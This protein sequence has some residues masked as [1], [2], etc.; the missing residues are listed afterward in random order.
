M[1]TGERRRVRRGPRD[2]PA[3]LRRGP[4]AHGPRPTRARTSTVLGSDLARKYDKH[5]GDT[6]TLRA[7]TF[8]VVGILEPTLTAPDK[9]A[10]IPLAAAQQLLPQ[11][12]AADDRGHAHASDIAT[13]DGRLPDAGHGRRGARRAEIGPQ[14]PD[15]A[16]MTGKDFDQQIGGGDRRSSTR[17]SSGSP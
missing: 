15:V 10:S 1:I 2:L 16:T 14:V 17:S 12:A 9:A 5:V 13:V 8:T 6:I 3:R 4:G 7:S 11:D